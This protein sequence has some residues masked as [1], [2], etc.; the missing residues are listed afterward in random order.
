[1]DP[2]LVLAATGRIGRLVVERLQ[3]SGCDVRCLVRDVVR[4]RATLGEQVSL[5]QGDLANP[6]ALQTAMQGTQS[7]FMAS[8]VAPDMATLQINAAEVAA[9]VGV[10]RVVKLSGSAW[11]MNPGS[12]TRVGAAHA[13]VEQAL[14]ELQVPTVNVRPNAFVQGMLGRIPAQLRQGNHFTL[15]SEVAKVAYTDIRDIADF[16]TLALTALSVPEGTWEITGP[17]AWSGADIAGELSSLLGRSIKCQ[18]LSIDDSITRVRASGESD[19]VLAHQRE[20]LE[21]IV[22]GAANRVTSVFSDVTG[23]LARSPLGYLDEAL[24]DRA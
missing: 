10:A 13:R 23:T 4:A 9:I 20:V 24:R 17:S 5:I 8:A 11:T 16:C 2:I 18:I 21:L 14:S 19:Y 15:V 22:A 7:V 12:M 3:S 1:M 6:L